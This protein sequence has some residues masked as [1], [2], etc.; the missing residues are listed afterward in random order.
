MLPDRS[1]PRS[2]WKF[3]GSAISRCCSGGFRAVFS[4]LLA[5]ILAGIGIGSLAGG[6]IDRRTGRPAE[7]FMAVQALFVAS[8]LT[9]LAL[10]DVDV[11]N[12]R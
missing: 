2:A 3:S 6:A 11:I 1:W 5:I 8:T 12:R 4:L 7:W 9:G 10:A